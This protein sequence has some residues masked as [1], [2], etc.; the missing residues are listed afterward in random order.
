[1]VRRY[2]VGLLLSLAIAGAAA[3]A[4]T[5][6][7]F[8]GYMASGFPDNAAVRSQ[9]FSAIIG[10]PRD[11]AL[12]YG[13]KT[14]SSQG[15]QVLVRTIKRSDDFFVEFLNKTPEGAFAEAAQGS[16][17]IQRSNSKGYIVQARIYLQDDPATYAR[18]YA[19]GSGTKLDVILCGA[20]VKKG[21]VRTI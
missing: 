2:G 6:S 20:V 8:D 9:L 10:A 4:E 7:S 16:C 5:F 12:A 14:V 1:M 13:E 18:L 17:V 19:S 15:N 3:G 21:L 11:I